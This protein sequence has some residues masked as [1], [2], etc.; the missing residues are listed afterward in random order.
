MNKCCN[1]CN[2]KKD[3]VRYDYSQGG[4]IHTSYDGY[5]CMIFAH[6]GLI[7]HMTGCDPSTEQCEEYSP[8]KEKEKEL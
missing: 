5:A 3:L 1:T 2:K 8:I 7:V 4:C 6:E